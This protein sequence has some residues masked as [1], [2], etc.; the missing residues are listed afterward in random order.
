MFEAKATKDQKAD[1]STIQKKPE[2]M[3]KQETKDK[4]RRK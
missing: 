3:Q 4:E 1:Q 2:S